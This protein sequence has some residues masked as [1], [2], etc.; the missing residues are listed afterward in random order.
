MSRSGHDAV[1]NGPAQGTANTPDQHRHAART[2]LPPVIVTELTV[3][4]G[5]V[6]QPLDVRRRPV[7][8]TALAPLDGLDPGAAADPQAQKM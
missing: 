1:D 8:P 3:A 4:R 6:R 5:N 7:R 2:H